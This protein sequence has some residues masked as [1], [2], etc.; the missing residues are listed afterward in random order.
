LIS[1]N[2]GCPLVGELIKLMSDLGFRLFDICGQWRRPDHVLWQVDLL[3][4][5]LKSHFVPEPKLDGN[6][7][8]DWTFSNG[9]GA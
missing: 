6:A 7:F 4:V 5:N 9:D 2:E 8:S 1:I 3:F